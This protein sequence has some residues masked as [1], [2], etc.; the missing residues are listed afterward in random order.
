MLEVKVK[1]KN[2]VLPSAKRPSESSR[3]IRRRFLRDGVSEFATKEQRRIIRSVSEGEDVS[4]VSVIDDIEVLNTKCQDSLLADDIENFKYYYVKLQSVCNKYGIKLRKFVKSNFPHFDELSYYSLKQDLYYIQYKF[5]TTMKVPFQRAMVFKNVPSQDYIINLFKSKLED[6]AIYILQVVS[7]TTLSQF[8]LATTIFL[9][10]ITGTSIATFFSDKV[11]NVDDFVKSYFFANQE[12]DVIERFLTSCK[13]IRSNWNEISENHIFQ[14]FYKLVAYFSTTSLAV[15]LGLCGQIGYLIPQRRK[16]IKNFT[17]ID[18][19]QSLGSVLLDFFDG[20]YQ[21]YIKGN[22]LGFIHTGDT[23]THWL[24]TCIKLKNVEP[25]VKDLP[26]EQLSTDEISVDSYFQQIEEAI[27]QGNEIL[28]C[29]R[30]VGNSRDVSMISRYLNDL[31]QLYVKQLVQYKFGAT[32]D[33]PFSLLLFGEPGCGKSRLTQLLLRFYHNR[34]HS[35]MEYSDKLTYTRSST[36]HWDGA[37]ST[38]KYLILDDLACEKGL[39]G[40]LPE[41]MNDL[42]SVINTVPFVT[43]Q[44]EIDQKGKVFANHEFVVGTTNVKNLHVMRYFSTPGAL[45]RRFPVIVTVKPKPE[46]MTHGTLDILKAGTNPDVYNL[47]LERVKVVPAPV[48]TGTPG[49]KPDA[50]NLSYEEIKED[51]NI[52][53]FLDYVGTLMDTHKDQQLLY[54]QISQEPSGY[55][56][57]KVC[58][59]MVCICDSVNADTAEG[60]IISYAYWFSLPLFLI[61]FLTAFDKLAESFRTIAFGVNK[62]S[63]DLA[64]MKRIGRVVE[65]YY[66]SSKMFIIKHFK[67]IS[68]LLSSVV[69]YS[70]IGTIVNKFTS[71]QGNSFSNTRSLHTTEE[72][73]PNVYEYKKKTRLYSSRKCVTT[74]TQNQLISTCNK[75]TVEFRVKTKSDCTTTSSDGVH[76]FKATGICG[77]IFI[78]PL[79]SKPFDDCEFEIVYNDFISPVFIWD[80]KYVSRVQGYDLGIVCV[81]GAPLRKDIRKFINDDDLPLSPVEVSFGGM[82]ING[83]IKHGH[84]YMINGTLEKFDVPVVYY[85]KSQPGMCGIPI[86]GRFANGFGIIGFHVSGSKLFGH[87]W[88]Q[89]P[90]LREINEAIDDLQGLVSTGRYIDGF[91]EADIMCHKYSV[92]VTKTLHYKNMTKFIENGKFQVIGE[93]QGIPGGKPKC[94]VRRAYLH[95]EINAI[96]G[97]IGYRCPQFR[98]GWLNGTYYHP[99]QDNLRLIGSSPL[100]IVPSELDA[101]IESF[102]D[103][104]TAGLKRTK[105]FDSFKMYPLSDYEAINGIPGIRFIDKIKFTAGGGFDMFGKKKIYVHDDVRE[106]YPH[107][108][109]YNDEVLSHIEKLENELRGGR[110]SGPIYCAHLKSE[111]RVCVDLTKEEKERLPEN[112]QPNGSGDPANSKVKPPRVFS[113]TP[114]AWS[115]LVRKYFLPYVKVHQDNPFLFECA[116]GINA[117]CGDWGELLK[118]LSA[119]GEDRITASDFKKYDKYITATMTL[120]AYKFIMMVC[121]FLHYDE[122]DKLEVLGT[123]SS[124]PLLFS[125]HTLVR[126]FGSNPSGHP[127]TVIINSIIN[128]LYTRMAWIKNGYDINDFNDN[129]NLLTY[130]DDNI[131]GVSPKKRILFYRSQIRYEFNG[132]SCYFA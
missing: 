60:D 59:K 52:N 16:I 115:H 113:G 114:A 87:G 126:L 12:D 26:V 5:I 101:A 20:A 27:E 19:L 89:C 55:K 7:S 66:F 54:K 95:D 85:R 74:V 17:S 131:M 6:I 36:K 83:H 71:A 43:P 73:T 22:T 39:D 33:M 40:K 112:P 76:R 103:K 125:Q 62:L 58:N 14:K 10:S 122:I 31:Q 53:E 111:P 25:L 1:S 120:A 28:T 86:I 81:P 4:H 107:G 119:F 61:W 78:F 127:L 34:Y 11:S 108:K 69:L 68:I 75:N 106:G 3:T 118:Y 90:T 29:S 97:D 91:P 100:R 35:D 94:S 44:A 110:L 70:T 82:V 51:L 116:V 130:G 102:F 13:S 18:M 109:M 93:I 65:N 80:D 79:H 96:F 8:I 24:Q 30:R 2:P 121:D 42:I 92:S 88:A 48:K 98:I 77:N 67:V 117:E 15:S 46:F 57:C 32:R 132:L 123:E 72:E 64:R 105:L 23:Y 41:K 128:S 37:R 56:P 21:Y 47:T 49:F 99:F 9:K 45:L 84:E 104:V 63:S 129:V 124:F 38:H 50:F